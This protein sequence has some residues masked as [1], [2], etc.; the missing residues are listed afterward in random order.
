MKK[1]TVAVGGMM[2]G[3]CES[4]MNDEIRKA[5]S[6]SKVTSSHKKGQV[7]I[8]AEEDIDDTKINEYAKKMGLSENDIQNCKDNKKL[9]SD[10]LLVRENAISSLGIQATP[11]F[12]I[13]GKDGKELISGNK[14]YSDFAKYITQRLGEK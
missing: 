10:I 13:E 11:T 9:T 4:H 8:I 3:M 7:V 12:I 2:C 14:K 1:I 5:F 6:V